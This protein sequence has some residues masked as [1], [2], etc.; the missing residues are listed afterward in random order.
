MKPGI[1]FEIP[2]EYGRFLWGV[3]APCIINNGIL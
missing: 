3:L 2:N 1:S